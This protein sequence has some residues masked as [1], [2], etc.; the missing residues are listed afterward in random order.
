M[1]KEEKEFVEMTREP[2]CIF[3]GICSYFLFVNIKSEN[4]MAGI[5]RYRVAV[6][7]GV[8][9]VVK[10]LVAVTAITITIALML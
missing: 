1:L 8:L 6:M 9:L 5:V 7:L 2:N 10:V 4:R 3:C